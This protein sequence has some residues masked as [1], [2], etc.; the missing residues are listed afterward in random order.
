[1]HSHRA[2]ESCES[3]APVN[4]RGSTVHPRVLV[5]ACV[6]LCTCGTLAAPAAS[7]PAAACTSDM[8]CSLNGVCSAGTCVCDAPW[9]GPAC[10][11]LG[12]KTTPASGR[13]LYPESDPRNTWNGAIIRGEDGGYHLFSPIYKAGTL[14]G[15]T[16][17]LHGTSANVT[18][19]YQVGRP[20]PPNEYMH[21]RAHAHAHA[22]VRRTH[23]HHGPVA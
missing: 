2:P 18:G 11:V 6:Y 22:H 19:P 17:M 20:P 23:T 16:T 8:S 4:M 7:S 14:G 12:Y 13:S 15:T 1:M 5:V 9:K 21:T 3:K 10:G